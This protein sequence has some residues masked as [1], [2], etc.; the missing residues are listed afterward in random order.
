MS[1][2]EDLRGNLVSMIYSRSAEY[3]IRALVRVA[4][5]SEGKFA[6]V[7]DIASESDIP[8]H[9]LSKILQDLARVG[10]LRSSKGP[11]GGFRLA[12]APEEI[13]DGHFFL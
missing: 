3:A 9:F 4:E 13:R 6:L 8:Q 7:K 12:I 10:L 2:S 11:G 5:L 1:R